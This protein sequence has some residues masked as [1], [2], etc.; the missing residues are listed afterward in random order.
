M[1]TGQV[2]DQFLGL[3]HQDGDVGP[4]EARSIRRLTN[5]SCRVD[6]HDPDAVFIVSVRRIPRLHLGPE[7]PIPLGAVD[8]LEVQVTAVVVDDEVT[9]H[10]SFA[11][12]DRRK[13]LEAEFLSLR[14]GASV[15]LIAGGSPVPDE[16]VQNLSSVTLLLSDDAGTDYRR[17]AGAFGGSGSEFEGFWSFDPAPPPDA[18]HVHVLAQAPGH[19][20][21]TFTLDLPGAR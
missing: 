18:Q 15:H 19:E 12:D 3:W 17:T 10:L 4:T 8:G 16:L 11:N 1:D 20:R 2:L 6:Y 5:E 7:Q 9:V 13:V 21:V 14:E